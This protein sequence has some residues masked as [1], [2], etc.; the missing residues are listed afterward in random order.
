VLVSF[1]MKNIA[2]HPLIHST[3]RLRL[4]CCSRGREMARRARIRWWRESSRKRDTSREKPNQPR[5]SRIPLEPSAINCI[6][7]YAQ[8]KEVYQPVE[9]KGCFIL[10]RESAESWQWFMRFDVGSSV[11]TQNCMRLL[12]KEQQVLDFR[13]CGNYLPN[14]IDV[15]II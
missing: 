7:P 13:Y 6:L 4:C 12:P 2:E 10:Q 5:R 8:W 11:A 14:D 9:F 15:Y 3:H 1:A